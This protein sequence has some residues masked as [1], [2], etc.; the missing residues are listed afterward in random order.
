MD[1]HY[2]PRNNLWP[3]SQPYPAKGMGAT[4]STA[5]SQA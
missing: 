2:L 1:E 3:L 5:P 4:T